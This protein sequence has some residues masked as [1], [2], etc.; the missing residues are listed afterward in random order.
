MRVLA[1]LALLALA[2]ALIALHQ[3]PGRT[4]ADAELARS[5][6]REGL[7][8]TLLLELVRSGRGEGCQQ[9]LGREVIEGPRHAS[10]PEADDA[11]LPLAQLIALLLGGDRD[12]PL[13]LLHL[14]CSDFGLQLLHSVSE[15]LELLL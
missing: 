4:Q 8:L 5:S 9:I 1:H 6:L 3:L 7:V 11:I 15:V 10:S 2:S 13:A 12:L 14:R